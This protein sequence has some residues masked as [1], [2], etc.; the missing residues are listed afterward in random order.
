MRSASRQP[1]RQADAP[2]STRRSRAAL[3]QMA[4]GHILLDWTGASAMT[5]QTGE[6]SPRTKARIA[7]IF[8]LLAILLSV[9][10]LFSNGPL[11]IGCLIL[12]S[13]SRGR[14]AGLDG[15]IRGGNGLSVFDHH[16]DS[17]SAL[18]G[19][20]GRRRA[21]VE[22]L[23]L[24]RNNHGCSGLR[25]RPSWPA[26][27]TL[28]ELKSRRGHARSPRCYVLPGRAPRGSPSRGIGRPLDRRSRLVM[29]REPKSLTVAS[30]DIRRSA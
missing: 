9:L 5:E 2:R 25:G 28:C 3:D 26:R 13:T 8:Y 15:P 18:R 29:A 17:G 22:A 14:A 4:G 24:S 11:L 30:P 10:A 21:V 16:V 12:R 27:G 1:L 19:L 7:G 20:D 23:T 6:Q